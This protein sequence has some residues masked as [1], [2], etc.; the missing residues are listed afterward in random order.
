[1]NNYENIDMCN[2]L[3]EYLD[4]HSKYSQKYGKNTIV[5]MMVGQFYEI[6]AVI[7]DEISVGANLNVISDILNIQIS[8]RNKKIKEISYDNFLMAGFPD[9]A[10]LKFR[11]ILL[12][13]NYTIVKIDQTTPPPN[14]EREVTEIISPSTIIDKFNNLDTNNLVSIYINSYPISQNKNIITAGLSTIDISTGNNY[15]HRI[16]SSNEDNK[17]WNDEIYRLIQYYNPS[18]LIVHYDSKDINF[19]NDKLS[20]LWCIDTNIIHINKNKSSD[21]LKNSFQ[22]QFLSKYFKNSSMLSPIEYLGFERDPDITLSYIY[23][24]Q[25]IHEHKIENAMSLKK[26]QFKINREY[27]LLNHNCVEQLYVIDNKEHLSEKYSSLLS[28]LNKCS[29]A[30][31]RRLCKERIL[32]PILDKNKLNERYNSVELFQGKNNTEYIFN[33]CKNELKKIID[34]EKL[35]RKMSLSILN[36]YEFYSIHNSYKF[37][38]KLTDILFQIPSM[39]EWMNNYLSLKEDLI[40]FIQDYE[41]IFNIDELEKWSLQNMESSV[42]Q[43]TIYPELDELDN[44]I[45]IKKNLLISI[46]KKLGKY[47]DKNKDEIVKIGCNDKYGWHLYM[48]KNRSQTMKK[49]FQNLLNKEIE[50]KYENE[51]FLKINTDQIKTIQKGS[52]YHVDLPII[53]KLSDDINKLQKK[54]QVINKEN[55]IEKIK[56]YYDN[57]KN[58]M[59]NIVCLIGLIDLYSTSAKLSI[60]NVY[61]RPKIIDSDS[62]FVDAKDIRHPIVEKIQKDIPYVPNDVKLNEDGILLYGTNACGKSTLMKSIGLSIIM[63]QS[64]FFVPCSAFEYS[65]YTQIFT[66]ILN[67]D[68]IFKGQSSFAVEMSELRS[69]LVRSDN[70]SLVLGDELCSGTENISALCLVA[71]GLKTLSDIKCSF[72]FTSHLHQLMD[73]SLVQSIQNLNVY[74]LKIIYD[75]ENDLLIY[76]RKLEKGSG[77]P[78]YGLEVCKAMGL[79]KDFISLARSVQLETTGKSHNLLENKSHYNSE[80]IMDI[81]GICS[82]KSEETH[83]IKEQ[84]I[85]NDNNI[86]DHYHK[87]SKHNLV[88]LC[89]DCHHKVTHENLRIY[90]YIQT[91]KGIQLNYEYI[92]KNIKDTKKKFNENQISII[93]KY[94]SKFKNKKNSILNLELNE[95]IKI[96]IG[97]YNKI[98]ENKY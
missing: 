64:G 8:R 63:A 57:H 36:P 75:N 61:C 38:L 71:A 1:M 77:P 73:I 70:K 23:M 28:L 45:N 15:V 79:N 69:I 50:F 62:S 68:N 11:N 24:L 85:A 16:L 97:T 72:I 14:P 35:H 3:K 93:K 89:K 30:I 31:G 59:D 51:T 10:F 53:Y 41:S 84:C 39:K 48:T 17:N 9:H 55:Y 96:S 25:F 54:L 66:R 32:Y 20:Q 29:T 42:F 81:C 22:N 27:L 91:D 12:N 65:P 44:E 13:H 49:S 80:I 37:I 52:N 83:H 86:I 26:P 4:Y 90:G 58:I 88:P 18:E 7:N 82:Q 76:D 56:Y 43:K 78:I 60:E 95:N 19:N 46:S 6:Y 47:I 5:L 40:N 94:H 87:N 34:I 33:L 2:I 92:Q 21:F 74:H 98:I 67:N